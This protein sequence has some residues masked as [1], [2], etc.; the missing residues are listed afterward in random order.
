MADYVVIGAGSAGAVI[1]SR[2]SET[3]ENHVVLL[4]AGGSHK[5]FRL[6]APALSGTLWRSKYDWSFNT[7][8]QPNLDGRMPHWPRGKVLGGTSSINYMVYMRG[9]RDNYDAWAAL[10]NAGWGY[11]DVL[12]YFKKSERNEWGASEFHGGDG[13]LDVQSV[14]EPSLVTGLLCEATAEVCDVPLGVDFNGA[15]QDGTGPFQVTCRDRRRCSTAVA[16][17]EPAFARD[18]LQIVTRAHVQRVIFE[19]CRA[20]GVQYLEQGQSKQVRADREVVLSAGAVGSPQ[21]LMLSGVGPADHLLG[22]GLDVVHDLPGVG[23]NLQDHIIGGSAFAALNGVAPNITAFNQIRWLLR[24]LVSRRG[25]M[26][27]NIAEAGAFVRVGTGAQRPDIQL[28]YIPTGGV[29]GNI[30]H[31]NYTP[32]GAGFSL[33]PTLLYP[34]SRGEIRLAS[35]D[36]LDNPIIDPRYLS[37]P[38]DAELLLDAVDL[39]VEIAHAKAMDGAVGEPMDESSRR[40][41]SRKTRLEALREGASTLFHPVGT[42]RMGSDDRAVV[43]PTLRVRGLDGLRVADASIMPDIVGGNTNAPCIMIGERAAGLILG[44]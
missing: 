19:G 14:L 10:G 26:A 11:A 13:P 40:G 4:E 36:P 21:I 1:A 34:R 3:P 32:K 43:D 30:D 44:G 16:F 5:D 12:P 8:P 24:Y 9:H 6:R 38:A 15:S 37:E 29:E 17:L 22:K 23:Q 18:N 7:A 25:P 41:A 33:L 39:S 28:H 27:S 35:A 42:C 2:L 20:V 31:Q